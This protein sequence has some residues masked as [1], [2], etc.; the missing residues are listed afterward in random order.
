M[1]RASI[2]AVSVLALAGVSAHADEP[3]PEDTVGRWRGKATWKGCTVTGGP[4][5]TVEVTWKDGFFHASLGGVR[6]DLGD[7]TLSPQADG[8]TTG[9]EHD[10]EVVF[11][12]GASGRM[13]LAS[14]GG[15]TAVVTLAR[16]GSG[17][18][19]CDRLLALADVE[20][21]CDAAGD[22]RG[23]HLADARGKLG[24]WK[25]LRGKARKAASDACSK[26][27]DALTS[28][29]V[30]QGCLPGAGGVGTGVPEC[31]AYV[32][33]LQ[34]YAQ[35]G[36]L[37]VE[38]KQSLQQAVIQMADAWKGLRDPGVAPEARKAAADAC[39]QASD[40]LRQAAVAQGC[41]L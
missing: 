10:L 20:S 33:I 16:D 12:P 23:E 17:V 6:D 11:K 36:A 7:V 32:A 31:D 24:G 37:P 25:K 21:T 3:R 34:R 35:C 40:A 15:C 5:S 8:T 39:K 9:A 19:G 26:D 38:A 28:S 22:A 1:R 14:A 41:S 4:A 13:T 30:Q 18:A 29:L 2:V 27:A